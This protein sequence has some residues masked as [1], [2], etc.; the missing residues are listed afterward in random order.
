MSAEA[1][2]RSDESF[3][4]PSRETWYELHDFMTG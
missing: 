1:A 4:P 2:E 3:T